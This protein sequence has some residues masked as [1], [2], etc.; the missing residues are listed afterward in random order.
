[1]PDLSAAEAATLLDLDNSTGQE[2]LRRTLLELVWRGLVSMEQKRQSAFLGVFGGNVTMVTCHQKPEQLAEVT[3]HTREVYRVIQDACSIGERSMKDLMSSFHAHFGANLEGYKSQ[4]IIPS[5]MERGLIEER[6]RQ[7]FGLLGPMRYRLTDAGLVERQRLESQVEEA[8]LLPDVLARNPAG[9]VATIAGLGI[10]LLL[11]DDL[12]P[13]LRQYS[14]GDTSGAGGVSG[15][16][17]TGLASLDWDA[18]SSATE[19]LDS[20]FGSGDS[21]G[22]SDGGGSGGG[23]GGGGGD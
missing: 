3:D 21:G 20:S 18:F 13:E 4:R 8:R 12:W 17:D 1:M 16:D 22:F 7:L 15:L 9:A 6:G 23:D 19:A 5:L 14:T 2:A 10:M 11:M